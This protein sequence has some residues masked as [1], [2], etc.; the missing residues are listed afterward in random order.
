MSEKF[1]GTLNINS[2]GSILCSMCNHHIGDKGKSWK[3]RAILKEKKMQG[4]GGAP[5]SSG[6]KVLLRC[7]YCPNCGALLDSET[8]LPEDPFLEDI[9]ES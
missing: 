8:A 4:L 3:V 9:L 6:D 5:Y 2:A 1:T 7:F